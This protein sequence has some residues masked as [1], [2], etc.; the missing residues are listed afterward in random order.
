M[1]TIHKKFTKYLF[2][3]PCLPEQTVH[4][5]PGNPIRAKGRYMAHGPGSHILVAMT[6]VPG[7]CREKRSTG[8]RVPLAT[9]TTCKLRR[10]ATRFD[11]QNKCQLLEI[12]ITEP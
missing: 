8:A 7:A 5:S 9:C 12:R 1:K 6:P 2:I 11:H 10:S 4:T 3:T